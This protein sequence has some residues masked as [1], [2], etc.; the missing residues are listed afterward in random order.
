VQAHVL[1]IYTLHSSLGGCGAPELLAQLDDALSDTMGAWQRV[2][3]RA[4]VAA[5]GVHGVH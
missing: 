3:C 4:V 1:A 2:A 5:A